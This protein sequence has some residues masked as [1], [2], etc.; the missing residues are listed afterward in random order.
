[1]HQ[2]Y[3]N[4]Q[5]W[6]VALHIGNDYS[7]YH[8]WQERAKEFKDIIE[9]GDCSQV[10]DGIWTAEDAVRY[11]LADAL[12]DS[13]KDTHP[14]AHTTSMYSDILGNAMGQVDWHEVADSIL[15]E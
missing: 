14:L 15:A 10:E 3:K 8:Y 4:Y 12:K 13:L 6:N 11:L 5:T 1:M 2:G 7:V 9:Q